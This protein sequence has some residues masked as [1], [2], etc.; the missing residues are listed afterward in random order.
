[1]MSTG[2]MIAVVIGTV[3][4]LMLNWRALRGHALGR[5]QMLK[6]AVI[7]AAIIAVLTLIISQVKL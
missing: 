3:M 7:W 6:M 4:V 1:M 5:D 2:A